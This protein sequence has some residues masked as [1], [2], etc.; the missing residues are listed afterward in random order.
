MSKLFFNA[1]IVN[2]V[3]ILSACSIP[4]SPVSHQTQAADRLLTEKIQNLI[5]RCALPEMYYSGSGLTTLKA[6]WY[7]AQNTV[8]VKS[9]MDNVLQSCVSQGLISQPF[10]LRSGLSG[11]VEIHGR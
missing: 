3:L 6:Q 10:E 2:C 9:A 4:D 11:N 7:T 8:Y 1:L 5:I